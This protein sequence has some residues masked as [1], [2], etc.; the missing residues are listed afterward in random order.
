MNG[1]SRGNAPR[2]DP[3]S[4]LLRPQGVGAARG[5][6][7]E[8]VA[9]LVERLEQALGAPDVTDVGR[10]N[11]C[12]GFLLEREK[13]DVQTAIA[14]CGSLLAKRWAESGR[15]SDTVILAPDALSGGWF[16]AAAG[17][18]GLVADLKA[19]PVAPRV[20]GDNSANWDGL[21]PAVDTSAVSL[22]LAVGL[23]AASE[24][25][26]SSAALACV[27]LHAWLGDALRLA[28]A[29][30]AR[31]QG[32]APALVPV[33]QAVAKRLGTD[34][35]W[36]CTNPSARDN[37][38]LLLGRQF[39]TLD[40]L[41]AAGLQDLT[42]QVIWD[43]KSYQFHHAADWYRGL[44][45]VARQSGRRRFI[46]GCTELPGVIQH[47]RTDESRWLAELHRTY[48]FELELH[49]PA[50]HVAASLS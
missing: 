35:V 22:D 41:K 43:A 5:P 2:A 30:K 47:L 25:G 8:E 40:D 17:S 3:S 15:A 33:V 14:V 28:P 26:Y 39:T 23:W 38:Q 42:Q 4:I 34:G 7:R 46:L 31:L 27:T 36:L 6:T 21:S 20:R 9:A 18:H 29:L 48:G 45:D 12:L 44:M 11:E 10:L 1:A 49:D 50:A 32:G 16:S 19:V 37:R 24:A 13:T